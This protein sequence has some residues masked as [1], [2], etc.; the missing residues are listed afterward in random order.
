VRAG[1][2]LSVA[3][4]VASGSAAVRGE[5][6][7][8]VD[9]QNVNFHLGPGAV[10]EVRRLQG[11]LLPTRQGAPPSFDDLK[12]Y[13]LRIDAGEVAMTP[14]S[15]TAVLNN[16]V[17]NYDK[18]PI[19]DIEV[20]IENGQLKQK[21]TLHKGVRV[22]FTIVADLSVTPDGRIRLH[23]A[24]VKAAGIPAAGIMKVFHLQLEGLIASN[25]AHGFEVE[26]NDV[27][28]AAE[29]M[30]P[31]P[32]I[33]GRLTA[34][35]I[36]GDRIV[37]VFGAQRAHGPDGVARNYM[38]YRGGALTFGKLTMNDT[39]LRLI[40]ADPRDPF[41]FSPAGY[42]AQLTAGYS[43]SLPNGGLRTFMPDLDAAAKGAVRRA[44]VLD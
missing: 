32:R 28:L 42:K 25:R 20:S 17:F 4:A 8:S 1:W 41:E 19:T 38:Y 30:F 13:T 40:D 26:G 39:D 10:L 24:S 5:P 16:T 33:A 21:G 29:H 7:V 36:D 22:P 43:K 14:S 31:E 35:R 6:A 37:E 15:L 12:S 34:I 2:V 23:P 27:L 3:L 9:F 18:A 11:A 44:A